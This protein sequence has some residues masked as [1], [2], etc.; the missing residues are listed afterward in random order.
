[1]PRNGCLKLRRGFAVRSS[2]AKY[3]S[4]TRHIMMIMRT[5]R[6]RKEPCPRLHSARR[7]RLAQNDAARFGRSPAHMF[8][9]ERVIRVGGGGGSHTPP[10]SRFSRQTNR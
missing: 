10:T 8:N 7:Q 9:N 5:S 3:L 4:E 6:Q 1:M 2:I